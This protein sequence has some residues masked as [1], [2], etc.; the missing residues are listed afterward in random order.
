MMTN[1][2]FDFAG[3][4]VVVTGGGEGVG[5]SFGKSFGTRPIARSSPM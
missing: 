2:C 3:R 1:Q 4:S 5:K